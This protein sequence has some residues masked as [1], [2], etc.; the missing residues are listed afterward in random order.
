[1]SNDVAKVKEN[2]R[3]KAILDR[4][5]HDAE[6]ALSWPGEEAR[7]LYFIHYSLCYE[8]PNETKEVVDDLNRIEQLGLQY[9]LEDEAPKG[10]C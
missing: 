2:N 9:W 4:L 10:S 1:M 6:E 7:L 8:M 5:C 3:A